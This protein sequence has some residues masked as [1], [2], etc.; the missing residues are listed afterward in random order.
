MTSVVLGT[1]DLRQALVAVL[2]HAEPDPDLVTLHRV[3]LITT[4]VNVTVV[5]TNRYTVGLAIASI[6]DDRHGEADT[7]DLNPTEVKEILSLFKAGKDD[8]GAL[9]RIDAD[10]K[11]VTVTD[12][13]GLFDGKSYRLPRHEAD[14]RFPDLPRLVSTTL[15][16]GRGVTPDRMTVSGRLLSYFPTAAKAYGSALTIEPAGH[17]AVLVVSCGEEFIGLL[18]PHS[19]SDDTAAELDEWR[20]A[21]RRRLPEAPADPDAAARLVSET[22]Q[23]LYRID[24]SEHDDAEED[25]KP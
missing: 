8:V 6:E 23:A 1:N 4:G 25:E 5:A 10:A 16:R 3:R 7:I 20:N 15:A 17:S 14:D 21:W 12:C 19:I 2:P 18:M 22:R 13:A 11:H 9:L 24:L